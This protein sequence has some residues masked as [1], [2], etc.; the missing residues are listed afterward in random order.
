MLI[1]RNT[2]LERDVL[3]CGITCY[4]A[5]HMTNR[6]FRAPYR[7]KKSSSPSIPVAFTWSIGHL[8]NGSFHFSFLI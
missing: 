4:T 1:F 5:I 7:W 3:D 6:I 2:F 8:R